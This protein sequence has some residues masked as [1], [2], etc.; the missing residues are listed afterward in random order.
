MKW[1]L[2]IYHR[3]RRL[4]LSTFNIS[5]A[6]LLEV[7]DPEQN[8]SFSD[9][10]LNVPFDLSSI[11]FI[12]TANSLETIPEPLLDRMEVIHLNGYTFE[13]KLHIARSHLLPKQAKAHGL[14]PDQVIISDSVLLKIAENYTRESGVRSLERTI[15]AVV[16]AKCVELAELRETG[17]EKEY[18]PNVKLEDVEEFL[19]VCGAAV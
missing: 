8:N 6:A 13:E 4:I 1:E 2:D 10:Y 3:K 17:R 5:A 18:N 19:G 9:H 16:R 14:E 15:A 11:L 12:A 7:L